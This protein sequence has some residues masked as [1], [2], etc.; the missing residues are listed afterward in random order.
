MDITRKLRVAAA[1]ALLVAW[2]ALS[3]AGQTISDDQPFPTEAEVGGLAGDWIH[4]DEVVPAAMFQQPPALN[5]PGPARMPAPSR[6][7]GSRQRLASVPNMFGD[8]GMMTATAQFIDSSGQR[9]ALV[10]FD[11][12]GAGGSRRV[13]IGENNSPI[14]QDRVFFMYNHFHN[15]YDFSFTEFTPAP[16]PVQR[17]LPIDRYTL[18]VEKTFLDEWWSVELRMPFNGS[19][20]VSTPD[21]NV[22][23]GN[24]GNLAVIVKRLLY[25]DDFVASAVGL[26]IDT[27]T[28]SSVESQFGQAELTF[29][30]DAVHLLPY[31]GAVMQPGDNLFLTGFLQVDVATGGNEVLF[32]PVG[33]PSRSAGEFREQN[34]LYVDL[35]GGYWLYR[36]PYAEWVNGVAGLLEFHYTTSLQDADTVAIAVPALQSQITNP[37]NRFDVVNVSAGLNFA[38]GEAANLR[39]AGVFPLGDEPDR[40]FFDS[41][42]QVQFNH[43]Y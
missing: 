33:G 5:Q 26:G 2:A 31:F 13:K 37:L 28:G 38:F 22:S 25:A 36:D 23:G 19:L 9:E 15:V 8:F 17:Q 34:L 1:A 7:L 32:G 11:I 39:V 12:P 41:E 40:R 10:T 20:D 6:S 3:S 21:F 30:N 27:P 24:Y 35:G 29:R 14:P 18:G 42:V 43:R 4:D 16:T